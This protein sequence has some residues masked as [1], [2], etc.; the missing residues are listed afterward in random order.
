MA[1]NII[2][3]ILI[4]VIIALCGAY[5]F[6]YMREPVID[7]PIE[8]FIPVVIE[9]SVPTIEPPILRIIATPKPV[10]TPSSTIDPYWVPG[11]WGDYV[12]G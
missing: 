4:L 11:P 2:I 5:W 6:V 12:Y 1:K 10:Q 9:T 8:T 3:A 7:P